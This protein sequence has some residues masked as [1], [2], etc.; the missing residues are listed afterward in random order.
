MTEF[1]KKY[2][3]LVAVIGFLLTF[4]NKLMAVWNMPDKQTELEKQ[5]EA[6]I[7]ESRERQIRQET[8]IEF[9]S[10]D[11]MNANG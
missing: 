3:P 8:I 10:K 5:V 6:Y 2:W 11:R 4:S 9:L 1:I 7:Q